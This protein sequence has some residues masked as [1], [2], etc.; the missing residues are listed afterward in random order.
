LRYLLRLNY[1]LEKRI[2][3]FPS[4]G[5]IYQEV[6]LV[7]QTVRELF[8]SSVEELIIDSPEEYEKV[9]DYLEV[10][11]PRLKSRVKLYSSPRPLFITYRIEE[12]IKSIHSPRVELPSGGY[13]VIQQTESLC[14]IDVNTGKFVG[15]KPSEEVGYLTNKEAAEEIARQIRLRNLVGIIVIDFISLKNPH[16]QQVIFQ[17][18]KEALK[19]DKAEVDLYSYKE[20]GLVAIA[21][22]RKREPLINLLTEECPYCSGAGR[23]L[24][25]S[26]LLLQ[27]KEEIKG[28]VRGGGYELRLKVNPHLL[29]YFREKERELSQVAKGRVRISGD[30]FLKC[31]NYL[32]ILK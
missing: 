19:E 29:E 5:L 27:V 31:D 14:A 28:L 6:G 15:R 18:M 4:P 3:S 11:Y 2:E 17:K 22:Q 7:H 9:L 25:R 8:D 10:S 13:I 32:L 20:L 16:H 21:R 24:R 30:P 26:A 12:E 23:T 1:S